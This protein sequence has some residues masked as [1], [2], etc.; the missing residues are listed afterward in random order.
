MRRSKKI[1]KKTVIKSVV[2][3]IFGVATVGLIVGLSVDWTFPSWI[4]ISGSSTM[5]Q[6]LQ[7]ISDEYQY[8]EVIVDAGGSSVGV[9]NLI[10]GKKN[11]ASSSK[12]PSKSTA[13]IP[14]YDGNKAVYGKYEKQWQDEK[15]KT[16]SVAFDAIGIVY[17][18]TGVLENKEVVMTPSTVL[19]LYL[20][21]AG[22]S[23]VNAINLIP[24]SYELNVDNSNKLVPFA[25][26]G[27]SVQSGTG[28]S[29]LL[30]SKLLLNEKGSYDSAGVLSEYN[31]YDDAPINSE[32][33][34]EG[35]SI[36]SILHSGSYG[37]N[38]KTTSES[39]L[40]T[41]QSMKEYTGSGI[42]ITYLSSGFIKSNYSEIINS[43]YSIAMYS[44]NSDGSNKFSLLNT[45]DNNK[46]ISDN[47]AIG[48][49]WYRPMNLILSSDSAEYIK[50]FIQWI[51]GNMLFPN[52]IIGNIYIDQ[53]F[54]ALDAETLK[55]MFHPDDVEGRK[56]IDNI[57]Q[58]ALDNPDSNYDQYLDYY[59]ETYNNPL[60]WD[61]FWKMADDYQLIQSDQYTFRESSDIWYGAY[62]LKNE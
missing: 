22:Y 58:F 29:F 34:P 43:G 55:T 8:S 46:V 45:D 23:E 48:Y 1:N 51:L 25:R 50:Y 49:D 3:S 5:Q 56:M 32:N 4:Y 57:A 7:S 18:N 16:V 30:D 15:I 6:F 40:Q 35:E 59:K 52:S 14:A 33:V 38:T 41:W 11:I 62:K 54:I 27:G 17:K 60:P 37:P 39:N 2:A 28:E 10:N 31:A 47:V 61:N 36:Y 24:N 21:F 12:S 26:T 13:G 9:D 44:T 19:W 42:P 20:A 53:G